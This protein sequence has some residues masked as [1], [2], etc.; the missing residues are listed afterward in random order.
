MHLSYPYVVK[1]LSAERSLFPATFA[2]DRSLTI[3]EDINALRDHYLHSPIVL[4]CAQEGCSDS[5]RVI[6]YLSFPEWSL[7][8]SLAGHSRQHD[9]LDLD[10]FNVW[11]DEHLHE[12]GFY[13]YS[14]CT[15]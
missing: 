14:L 12:V 8:D 9:F 3:P 11:L 4:S 15:L 13:W 5:A 7:S 2:F 1:I 10:L 6:L